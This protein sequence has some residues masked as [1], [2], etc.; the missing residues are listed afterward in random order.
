M[1]LKSARA[2]F[3][4]TAAGCGKET[5]RERRMVSMAAGIIK[6]KTSRAT[7]TEMCIQ[8]IRFFEFSVLA[9]TPKSTKRRPM[10]AGIRA[11][12][13]APPV[14]DEELEV[15]DRKIPGQAGRVFFNE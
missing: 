4:T 9:M 10:P 2:P 13:C 5:P 3:S 14:P 15:A 1:R 11:V 7:V 6:I 8:S 12:G